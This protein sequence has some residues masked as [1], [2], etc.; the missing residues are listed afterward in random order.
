M[1]FV[2]I[3]ITYHSNTTA[4]E[5]TV[6]ELGALGTAAIAIKSVSPITTAI[7]DEIM[8]RTLAAFETTTIDILVNNAFTGHG[9]ETFSPET[10]HS[11]FDT[12]VLAP[13]L[14]TQS[15]L[16]HI[17]RGGSIINI[18][19]LVARLPKF[20]GFTV[21]A[22]SKAALEHLTRQLATA[23]AE[24]YG[25]TIN[26]VAPGIV[27]TDAIQA[28]GQEFNQPIIDLATAEKRA[29]RPEEI[30]DIVAWLCGDGG[31]RWIN[32]DTIAASGGAVMS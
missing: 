28:Q 14:L 12:N 29:G 31:A 32:G 19:S 22:I 30:A 15:I 9:G 8:K 16:P 3:T 5:A 23:Y 26:A 4:A 21:Y 27:A 11:T 18:S 10:F 1:L 13:L 24:Q 6:S 25:I 20:P 17:A 2:Q 7:T